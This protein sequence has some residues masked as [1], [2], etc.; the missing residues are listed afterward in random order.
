MGITYLTQLLNYTNDKNKI[1][2]SHLCHR[3]SSK[4]YRLMTAEHK[5]KEKPNLMQYKVWAFHLSSCVREIA[6]FL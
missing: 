2:P 4:A 6:R 3:G 1:G 5:E